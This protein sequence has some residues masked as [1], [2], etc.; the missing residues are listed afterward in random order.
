[1]ETASPQYL[2]TIQADHRLIPRDPGRMHLAGRNGQ[3]VPG[4]EFTLDIIDADDQ[5]AG[6]DGVEFVDGVAMRRETG[7]GWIDVAPDPV[8]PLFHHLPQA[9]FI[10]RV[11][12]GSVPTG[13]V[14][15]RMPA[16]LHR[17]G[18]GAYRQDRQR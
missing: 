1:M 10:E 9:R 18:G 4:T 14:P 3:H 8:T 2:D 17:S 15:E 16:V 13:Q 6:N 7:A 5:T 12:R 11:P